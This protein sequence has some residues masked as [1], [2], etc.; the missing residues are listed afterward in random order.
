MN[1][2]YAISKTMVFKEGENFK[3]YEGEKPMDIKR[4]LSAPMPNYLWKE[5]AKISKGLR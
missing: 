5:N 3:E 4:N 2:D 1:E